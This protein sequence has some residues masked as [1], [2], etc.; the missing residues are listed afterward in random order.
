MP[1]EA[2]EKKMKITYLIMS[3]GSK[4]GATLDLKIARTLKD[5]QKIFTQLKK[6]ARKIIKDQYRS[7][8]NIGIKNLNVENVIIELLRAEIDDWGH[9]KD[10]IDIRREFVE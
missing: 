4:T 6:K 1:E 3:S 10:Y 5:A 7:L 2:K 9:E 8:R